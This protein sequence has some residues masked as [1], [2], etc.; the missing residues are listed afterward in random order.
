MQFKLH[1]KETFPM[2]KNKQQPP[3][4]CVKT[5]EVSPFPWRVKRYVFIL[6]FLF[7][8]FCIADTQEPALVNIKSAAPMPMSAIISMISDMTGLNIVATESVGKTNVIA[9]AR[10]LSALEVLKHIALV[11]DFRVIKEEDG[12]ILLLTAQECQVSKNCPCSTRVFPLVNIPV[13]T[14]LETIKS[15]LSETGS[16]SVNPE[17]NQLVVSDREEIL[18][19]IE[20]AIAALDQQLTTAVFETNE[21]SSQDAATLLK[22]I[23]QPPGTIETDTEGRFIT[24]TDTPKNIQRVQTALRKLDTPP[25]LFTETFML[26]HASCEEIGVTVRELFDQTIKKTSQNKIQQGNN[27]NYS[28]SERSKQQQQSMKEN[29][30]NSSSTK[31]NNSPNPSSVMT[32]RAFALGEKGSVVI[33]SRNNAIIVTAETEFIKRLRGIIHSMDTELPPF[34]YTF[35]F[36]EMETLLLEEKLPALLCTRGESY[37]I[38]KD[39]HTVSFFTTPNRANV[40][41]DLF[42]EWDKKP[43]QV[44]IEAKL[45]SV[46]DNA[47]KALGL[48]FT[49]QKEKKRPYTDPVITHEGLINLAPVVTAGSPISELSIGALATSDYNLFI[50]AITSDS[51]TRILTEPRIA[52][53]NNKAASFSDA[54]QEPYTVVTVDGTTNTVLEDVRFLDVGVI[55]EVLPHVNDHDEIKLDI[56]LKLSHLVEIRD[57]YPV[58]DTT[59]AQATSRTPHGQPVLL[60]GLKL[61]STLEQRQGVP[62]LKDIP[63]VGRL[64]RNLD[65]DKTNRQLILIVTPYIEE[66]G[67]K[68]ESPLIDILEEEEYLLESEIKNISRQPGSIEAP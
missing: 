34:N 4:R 17:T 1:S 26:K 2:K 9:N 16:V 59:I 11:H 19:Q 35:A 5:L 48:N 10:G 30:D 60:G 49:A 28:S 18:T 47:V 40:I 25:D 44:I 54:R 67:R 33:D 15:Y 50:R 21:I 32:L 8:F 38:D 3:H 20:K 24:V 39:N 62:L 64:F 22:T 58:V 61:R 42:K 57:N 51:E 31:N 37:H 12:V 68:P 66:E 56:M 63:L 7:P 13:T 52:T 43:E 6:L 45:L 65:R 23:V 55:L 41:L 46:S 27:Q 29:S 36:A 14:M 53:L